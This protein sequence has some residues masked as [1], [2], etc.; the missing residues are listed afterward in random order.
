MTVILS[1]S[2][3]DASRTKPNQSYVNDGQPLLNQSVQGNRN[4]ISRQIISNAS[5]IMS[6]QLSVAVS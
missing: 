6:N 1:Q 3:G 5:R 4:D 2:V